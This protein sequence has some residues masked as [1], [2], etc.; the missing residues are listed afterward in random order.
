[1][2]E[3]LGRPTSEGTLPAVQRV[4]EI[5]A[6]FP[7]IW[8]AI[9]AAR[10][11]NRRGSPAWVTL[12]EVADALRPLW[13]EE[14]KRRP[15]NIP[16]ERID[17]Q[18]EADVKSVALY[19]TWRI[20]KGIYRFD[21]D[22]RQEIERTTFDGPLPASILQCLPEWCVFV[23]RPIMLGRFNYVG[24][25]AGL[26]DYP[27]HT[28]VLFRLVPDKIDF[29]TLTFAIPLNEKPLEE[30][31]DKLI[32]GMSGGNMT[33]AM[34]HERMEGKS[35]LFSEVVAPMLALTLFLCA[36]MPQ[37]IPSIVRPHPQRVKRGA[38]FFAPDRITIRE[39][40]FNLGRKI[41][42]HNSEQQHD[43]G[44]QVAPH[45]RRAHWHTY[46]YGAGK[47]LRKLQWTHAIFVN[48]RLADEPPTTIRN[49]TGA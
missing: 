5:E 23:E 9:D 19:A 45:L 7:R 30:T 14:L 12:H 34:P 41:R 29:P 32:M 31:L 1:M 10:M 21:P 8:R 20:T 36:D 25:F 6:R 40:A 13:A 28:C 24:F 22:A 46:L 3:V 49:V 42:Q 11:P 15:V 38:R 16:D 37:E 47:R 27:S 33:S 43:T 18:F 26:V 48:S 39:I 44:A 2:D 35:G 17:E 4:K